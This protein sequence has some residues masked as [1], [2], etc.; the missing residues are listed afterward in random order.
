MG[1]HLEKVGLTIIIRHRY[2][3]NNS[4][5]T[6]EMKEKLEERMKLNIK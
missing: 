4:W 6:R 2:Q 5:I 1:T 3:I